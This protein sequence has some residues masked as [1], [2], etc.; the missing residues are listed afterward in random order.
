M[1][2]MLFIAMNGAK[3][4]MTAQSINSNNLANA[5]TTGFK[6][7]FQSSL[8]QQV[9]GPGLPSRVYAT[10]ENAGIDHTQGSVVTTGRELDIAI[11]GNGLIAVQAAD[12]S[13]AYTRAGDLKLDNLGRLSNGAGY[14]I[15]GDGGPISIPANAKFE[16]GTDGTISI[17]PIGQAVNSMAIL[18]RIK[19]VNPTNDQLEKGS[20]GLMHM[21]NGQRATVDASVKV[22]SG[23][24]ESSNVNTVSTLVRMIELARQYETNIKLMK[25]AEDTD[26]AA[27]EMIKIS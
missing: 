13:E 1:D 4:I 17:Q 8:S 24:L 15:L 27:A 6:A 5:S 25:S 23:A 10:V 14:T 22:V 9:Y 12:G 18:D 20:D 26:R 11:N 21:R 2:R 7:D 3:Q 16:V 19:L